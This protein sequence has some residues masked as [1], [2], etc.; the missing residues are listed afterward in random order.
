MKL[1]QGII[2]IFLLFLA[3]C[4]LQKVSFQVDKRTAYLGESVEL[5]WK[6]KKSAKAYNIEIVGEKNKSEFNPLFYSEKLDSILKNPSL[7]KKKEYILIADSLSR[8]GSILTSIDSVDKFHIITYVND[9]TPIIRYQKVKVLKPQ[10]IN[11]SA[12][13]DKFDNEVVHL[14]WETKD[15]KELELENIKS[16]L[17]KKGSMDYKT[18]LEQEFTL[19]GNNKFYEVSETRIVGNMDKLQRPFITNIKSIDEIESNSITFEIF[20][21][22]ISNYPKEVELK[23]LVV[24]GKGNFVSN[25]APPFASSETADEY[26]RKLIETVK[27]TTSEVEFEVEEIHDDT[28]KYDM[29]LVLDHS[30]SMTNK[31]KILERS[32]KKFIEQKYIDDNYSIVKFDDSLNIACKLENDVAKILEAANFNGIDSFG[33]STALFAAAD[34]GL[35]SLKNGENKK[36]VVLFSDGYENASFQYFG[37]Y[38]ASLNEL[39]HKIKSSHASLFLISYGDNFNQN[40]I[41]ELILQTNGRFYQVNQLKDINDVYEDIKHLS[42]TYYKI[43]YRPI[44]REGEHNVQLTY[45]N[46]LDNAVTNYIFLIGDQVFDFNQYNIDTTAYWCDSL[47]IKAGYKLVFPPQVLV[48]FEFDKYDVKNKYSKILNNFA[49]YLTQHPNSKIVIYGHT[50][51]NGTN[52]YNLDLSQKRANQVADFLKEKKISQARIKTIPKAFTQ[53]VHPVEKYEWQA[54]ENR[55]V[56]ILLWDK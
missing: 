25:L 35:Q 3:S 49:T 19:I 24:D 17:P 30:G 54:A 47:I 55:R 21:S 15:I 1:A 20:E 43:K 22:D 45:Y 4:S 28:T 2:I 5:S 32:V 26:F 36:V 8:K 39:V 16:K 40:L 29:S 6:V 42:R 34:L 46:E 33:G 51:S 14:S 27:T 12:I 37:E 44:M 10:I 7:R 50:D 11:F 56:E 9:G 31:T 53:P 52:E 38:S 41:N 18:K 13:R 48:N 23:V